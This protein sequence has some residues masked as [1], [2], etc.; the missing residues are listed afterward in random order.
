MTPQ[1][2][3]M[4]SPPAELTTKEWVSAVRLESQRN[5]LN[6]LLAAYGYL[7]VVTTAILFLQGFRAWGFQ[8]DGSLLK[9]LGAATIGEIGGLLALTFRASFK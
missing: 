4:K 6:F 2:S 9:W 7:L 8:L 1:Q 5:I 3:L